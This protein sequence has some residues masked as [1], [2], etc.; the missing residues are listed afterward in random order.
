MNGI[1]ALIIKETQGAFWPLQ[2]CEDT[3]ESE[4]GSGLSS[5]TTPVSSLIIDF[6]A[7]RTVR[8]KCLLFK[9]SSLRY[10]CYASP[11]R[12]RYSIKGVESL[13]PAYQ[14]KTV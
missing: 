5:D 11:N 13:A 14:C 8:N 4:P 12:L 2:P 6:S 7:Y 10:F 1:S 3:A 9:P